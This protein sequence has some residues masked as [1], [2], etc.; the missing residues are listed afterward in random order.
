MMSLMI[1]AAIAAQP[2][3]APAQQMPMQDGQMMDVNHRHHEAM[4]EDC[5]SK[6]MMQK[7]H[8]GH[9]ADGMQDHRSH[10]SK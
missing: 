3:A 6:E 9:D 7:M 5:C 10:G 4:K 1:A 2:A 8:S